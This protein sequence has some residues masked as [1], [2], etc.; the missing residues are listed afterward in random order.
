MVRKITLRSPLPHQD[1]DIFFFSMCSCSDYESRKFSV[2]QEAVN[3]EFRCNFEKE[4]T[5]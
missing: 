2:R 4:F 3:H 5:I 1:Y